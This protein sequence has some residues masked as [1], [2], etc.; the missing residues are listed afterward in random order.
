MNNGFSWIEREMYRNY[1]V[2]INPKSIIIRNFALRMIEIY[3]IVAVL[4]ALICAVLYTFLW[5]RRKGEM[6]RRKVFLRVFGCFLAVGAF[7]SWV[8]YMLFK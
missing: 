3:F 5:P 6:P 4:Y 2:P 1:T 8:F 7:L